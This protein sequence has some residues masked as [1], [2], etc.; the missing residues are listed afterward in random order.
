[1]GRELTFADAKIIELVNKN[2]VPVAMDDWFQRRRQ[3]AEGDF[4]RKVADQGPRKGSG[5][6]TR[7][8]IYAFTADGKL[9][10]YRNSQDPEVMRAFY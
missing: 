5:G 1:M 7:Q 3:D 8:G 2:F 4:F 10:Q 6:G 9:L